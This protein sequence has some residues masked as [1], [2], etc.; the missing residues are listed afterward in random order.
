MNRRRNK[1]RIVVAQNGRSFSQLI[2]CLRKYTTRSVSS[3]PS[4]RCME[5]LEVF[6]SRASDANSRQPIFRPHSSTACTRARATPCLRS[7]WFH[8]NP[9]QEDH[10]RGRASVDSIRAQSGLRKSGCSALRVQ[11]DANEEARLCCQHRLRLA[12]VLLCR[13]LRPQR[14]PH[15]PPSC[16]L[17]R[18]WSCDAPLRSTHRFSRSL[19]VS[20]GPSS[21]Q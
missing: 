20:A 19:I 16:H 13:H 10:R 15:L 4:P 1:H 14:L 3:N 8:V 6:S 2:N 7:S 12:K 5:W 9:F 18:A 21:L 17:L 11:R